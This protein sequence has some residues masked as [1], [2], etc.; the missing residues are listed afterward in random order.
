MLW[1]VLTAW[2]AE[3]TP[4]TKAVLTQLSAKYTG[5]DV[6]KG[7]F[8][9][10]TASVYGDQVQKGTVVLKR[11]GRIRWESQPDGKQFVCDGSTLWIY[12][13][14]EKQVMRIRGFGDQAASIFAV[15]GSMDKLGDMF[16]VRVAG[17]DAANGW[18]LALTPKAGQ[19]AQFKKAM[20]E[21]D[22]KL[23]LDVVRITDPFDVVTTIDFADVTLGGAVADDVFTFRVPAGVQVV[24]AGG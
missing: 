16:E 6:V 21:L 11:P 23:Q 19:D 7:T 10:T 2:G 12:D 24:D 9:Q 4:E 17:G 20:V 15:L 1:M 22:P 8:T 18:D 5:V 13:P 3:P 14:A